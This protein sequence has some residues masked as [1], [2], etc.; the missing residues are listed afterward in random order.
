[1]IGTVEAAASLVVAIA[2]VALSFAKGSSRDMLPYML[3]YFAFFG[4][5]PV[6]N[7]LM[8]GDIYH[9]TSVGLIG[10]ASVGLA[11]ALGGMAIVAFLVR[12]PGDPLVGVAVGKPVRYYYS[13]VVLLWAMSCYAVSVLLLRGPSLVVGD[14]ITRIAAAGPLHATYL[15]IQLCVCCLYFCASST[16][17]GRPAYFVNLATYIAYCLITQE[18]D[19]LFVIF[20]LL[21]HLQLFRR[22]PMGAKI[23]F[24][25]ILSALSATVLLNLRS[26]DGVGLSQVL[27]QGSVLFVDTFVMYHV[28]AA[29]SYLYGGSYV[30]AILSLLP[31]RIGADPQSL[32]NWLAQTYAPDAPGGYGFSLSGEAYINFGVLGIPVVF[33]VMAMLQRAV[34]LRIERG[35][36]WAYLSMLYIIVLMY[37]IRGESVVVVRML[38]YGLVLFAAVHVGSTFSWRSRR[39]DRHAESATDSNSAAS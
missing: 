8:G 32:T 7:F 36:V 28:P 20:S 38:A 21:L 14:K 15:T 26:G 13:A 1:M 2:L 24:A 11:L 37:T 17:R 35:H 10:D 18:R 30:D 9:G 33:A 5:G 6:A 31:T 25:A 29:E 12:V 27:N 34:V 22:R 39:R 3:A 23:S 19:F 16:P 4:F